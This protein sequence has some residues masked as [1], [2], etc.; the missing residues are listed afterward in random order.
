MPHIV[1]EI[2]PVLAQAM[3]L[4][5]LLRSIHEGFAQRGYASAA[6]LRSRVVISDVALSGT[7]ENEQLVIATMRTTV[8]RPAEIEQAMARYLHDAIVQAIAASA[9]DGPW[10]C[11]VFRQAVPGE[12]FIKSN[13]RGKTAPAD[14]SPDRSPI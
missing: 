4:K 7:D 13:G 9:F 10:Q 3:E 11:G 8:P 14:E 12:L 2:T 6:A 5:G 1:F